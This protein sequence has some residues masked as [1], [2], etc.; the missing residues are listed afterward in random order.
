MIAGAMDWAFK[1][2]DGQELLNLGLM[3]NITP[4]Y[5]AEVIGVFLAEI[6]YLNHFD[7][8][9]DCATGSA[10]TIASAKTMIDKITAGDEM[11]AFSSGI[12]VAMS[13]A[14]DLGECKSASAETMQLGEWLVSKAGSKQAM[15]DA[16]SANAMLHS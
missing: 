7:D 14:V 10:D 1:V 6:A 3:D 9:K 5:V 8:M 13:L 15:V 16:A 12:Q 11:A 4:K 2:P